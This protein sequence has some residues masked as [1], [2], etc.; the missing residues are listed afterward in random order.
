MTIFKSTP[1]P[2]TRTLSLIASAVVLP[3]FVYASPDHG[4][5]QDSHDKVNLTYGSKRSCNFTIKDIVENF[6]RYGFVFKQKDHALTED[7]NIELIDSGKARIA[8][9]G[10]LISDEAKGELKS[11]LFNGDDRVIESDQND[12]LYDLL[13]AYQ[14]YVKKDLTNEGFVENDIIG[15]FDPNFYTDLISPLLDVKEEKRYVSLEKKNEKDLKENAAHIVYS[16]SNRRGNSLQTES[17]FH[18]NPPLES[19]L[20]ENNEHTICITT[21]DCDLHKGA[22]F[23]T[24][25]SFPDRLKNVVLRDCNHD[26]TAFSGLFFTGAQNDIKLKSIR[27]IGFTNAKTIE[28][29][30]LYNNGL[31]TFS[32]KGLETITSIGRGFLQLNEQLKVVDLTAFRNLES[33]GGKLFIDCPNI[34]K[35]IVTEGKEG[36]FRQHIDQGLH[37]KIVVK[38]GQ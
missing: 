37:D 13:S 9:L 29:F 28:N 17:F 24:K 15:K 1:V 30:F 14:F 22:L 8:Y 32:A 4:E 21:D 23:I 25:A 31:T 38:G 18:Q 36:L 12:V 34:K 20:Q 27:L 35:I 3:M 26:V 5:Y 11:A 7:I 33:V 19:I 6:E 16:I 10:D 2:F